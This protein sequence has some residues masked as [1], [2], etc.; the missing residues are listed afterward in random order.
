LTAKD[1]QIYL[2][3]VVASEYFDRFYTSKHSCI[4]WIVK[5]NNGPILFS[6]WNT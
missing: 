5:S 6:S 4:D 2:S 1:L 3:C